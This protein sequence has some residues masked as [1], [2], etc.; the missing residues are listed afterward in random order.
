MTV[1]RGEIF[2][3]EIVYFWVFKKSENNANFKKVNLL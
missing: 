2:G 1:P 3:F